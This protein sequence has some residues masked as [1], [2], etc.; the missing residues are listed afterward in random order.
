MISPGD[1]SHLLVPYVVVYWRRLDP[2][3]WVYLASWGLLAVWWIGAVGSG[4]A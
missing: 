1:R 2:V 4:G 3:V